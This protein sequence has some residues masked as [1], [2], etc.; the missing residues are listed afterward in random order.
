MQ[1]D[2]SIDV[3]QT[4]RP[5]KRQRI[6]DGAADFPL[7]QAR[8]EQ[9]LEDVAASDAASDVGSHRSGRMSPTKQMQRLE[10]LADF[11]VHFCN[12]GD[13]G[14]EE[15]DIVTDM[16][17]SLQRLA[18]GIGIL[19][20]EDGEVEE[21]VQTLPAAER[22]SFG[23]PWASIDKDQRRQLGRMPDLRELQDIV[24]TARDY[25]RGPGASED[26]WNSD[27]HQPLLKMAVRTS[28]HASKLDVQSV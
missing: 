26:N 4:P 12:F 14:F 22:M 2:L 13:A 24:E 28:V 10:D 6:P 3:D 16:Q 17:V 21:L 1:S 27:V 25:D 9:S 20:Y 11:P 7:L 15:P 18:H 19:A 5:N 8:L 23:L